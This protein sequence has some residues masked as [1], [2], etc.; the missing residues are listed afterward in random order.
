MLLLR[1]FACFV[2]FTPLAQSLYPREMDSRSQFA[3]D[4][5]TAGTF[6]MDGS[7]ATLEFVANSQR[8]WVTLPVTHLA[9][10]QQLCHE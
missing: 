5:A 2:G 10:L 6:S 3:A 7:M 1:C 8:L 4:H 9:S